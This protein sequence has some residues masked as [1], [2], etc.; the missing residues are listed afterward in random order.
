MLSTEKIK[1]YMEILKII[2]F[3]LLFIIIYTYLGYGILLYAI[4]KIRRLFNIGK[5]QV[6]NPSYEP[7]AT[8][9]ITA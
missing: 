9:F 6:I 5:K 1:N 8:L 3:V 7:E 4:I 2:S